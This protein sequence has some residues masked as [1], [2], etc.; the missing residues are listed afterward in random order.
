MKG[1]LKPPPTKTQIWLINNWLTQPSEILTMK[2]SAPYGGSQHNE[3]K[4]IRVRLVFGVIMITSPIHRGA[5]NSRFMSVQRRAGEQSTHSVWRGGSYYQWER[6]CSPCKA[7][8]RFLAPRFFFFPKEGRSLCALQWVKSLSLASHT[9]AR[10][11]H[12]FV[13]WNACS[14]NPVFS[15]FLGIFSPFCFKISMHAAQIFSFPSNIWR[16]VGL[17]CS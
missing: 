7:W 5:L 10:S 1:H 13:H 3:L 2:R 9:Q 4:C 12:A 8:L 17:N 16:V 15:P 14:V 6:R 11:A